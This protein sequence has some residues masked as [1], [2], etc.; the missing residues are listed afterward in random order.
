MSCVLDASALLALLFDEPG[1]ER[2]RPALVGGVISTVNV[3]EVFGKLLS[4]GFVAREARLAVTG[5]GLMH[6]SFDDDAAARAAD[7]LHPTRSLGLSFA[8]RACL[9][10]GLS[11]KAPVLTA[12]RAWAKLDIGIRIEVIR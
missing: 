3:S 11:T 10:L 1:S 7:L 4:R 8:D 9:S 5:L 6:K 12:D 2:V